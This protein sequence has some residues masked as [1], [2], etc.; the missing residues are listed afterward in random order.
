VSRHRLGKVT[1]AV[2]VPRGPDVI[3][4]VRVSAEWLEEGAMIEFELP[5]NMKC[6]ACEGGGCDACERS[7]A[8]SV[9][10]KKELGE[11]VQVTLPKRAEKDLESTASGRTIVI[12]I[13][14]RG[15]L[16]DSP[17]LPRGLL[18]LSVVPADEAD[19]GV[20]RIEP[21]SMPPVLTEAEAAAEERVADEP[22]LPAG[23]QRSRAVVVAAVLLV[24]WILFLI[25]LRVTGRG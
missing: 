7:G 24:L 9:R 8:I 11:V 18:F 1:G 14:E 2:D 23:P 21:P 3:H 22:R 19:A 13:P 15:G 16:S 6:A 4:R 10:G 5:R 20:R 12:R 25:W 17:E